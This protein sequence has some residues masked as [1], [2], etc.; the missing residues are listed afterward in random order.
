MPFGFLIKNQDVMSFFFF[1]PSRCPRAVTAGLG[2]LG[3][4]YSTGQG[5]TVCPPCAAISLNI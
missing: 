2:S 3:D 1:P 5:R 4:P